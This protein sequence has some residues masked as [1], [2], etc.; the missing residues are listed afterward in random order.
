VIAVAQYVLKGDPVYTAKKT[1]YLIEAFIGL[2]NWNTL[3]KRNR[4][5]E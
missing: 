2:K 1:I 4:A 3:A 5:N